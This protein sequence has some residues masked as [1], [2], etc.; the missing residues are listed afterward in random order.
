LYQY[1]PVG[2]FKITEVETQVQTQLEAIEQLILSLAKSMT[3]ITRIEVSVVSGLEISLIEPTL[4]KLN[5][6]RLI[7][8]SEFDSLI[9]KDNMDR[10][11]GEFGNEWE[12]PKTKRILDRQYIK[13]F[14]ITPTGENALLTNKKSIS[15]ILDLDLVF[16]GK[17]FSVYQGSVGLQQ[18][19]YDDI[20]MTPQLVSQV[21]N[22]T[23]SN[24]SAD[25]IVPRQI[26]MQT[27]SEGKE[28]TNAQYWV[29]MEPKDKKLSFD[30]A[31]YNVFLTSRSFDKWINPQWRSELIDELPDYNNI[32]DMVVDAISE[33]FNMVKSVIRDGLTLSK[34]KTTWIFECDL[35]MLLLINKNTPELV[36]ETRTEVSLNI[37]NCDWKLTMI[38][39]L[40]PVEEE[41]NLSKI[42]L[43]SGRFHARSSR[44]GFNRD[45]GY[46][47]WQRM[48]NELSQITKVS[49]YKSNL[50]H[51]VKYKCLIE[52]I[53]TIDKLIVDVEDLMKHNRRGSQSWLF[54]R[55]RIIGKLLDDLNTEVIYVLPSNIIAKIDEEDEYQ[56]WL[57][58]NDVEIF[59]PEDKSSIHPAIKR[60]AASNAYY[61][62][63][64]KIP[65]G[66]KFKNL[67]IHGKHLNYTLD[68][69]II[70]I[71]KIEPFYEFR[72]ENIFEK[73]YSEYYD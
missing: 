17:P 9:L 51:L 70:Q 55:L 21:L 31:R 27:V 11:R 16:T 69:N 32:F 64:R 63:N 56:K 1:T 57:K 4:D 39:E 29:A 71:P 68:K 3:K 59:E 58:Q 22:L 72:T 48:K 23:A 67:R 24:K 8:L 41:D 49:E 40:R 61:V 18:E 28:V 35:E 30:K 73:L 42:A 5:K 7:K 60:A 6:N 46:G 47:V 66:D 26:N 45:S 53:P 19:G 12:N 34:D 15:E 62:G 44:R 36:A 65:K 25:Q 10:L 2:L 43:E 33:T 37:P 13:Q 38:I 54:N 14:E 50:S 20:E 52:I